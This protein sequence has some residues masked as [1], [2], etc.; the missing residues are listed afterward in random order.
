LNGVPDAGT[1]EP[2][3]LLF[4]LTEFL[5]Y[6]AAPAYL[7]RDFLYQ[8]YVVEKLSTSEIAALISSCQSTVG[9]YLKEYGIIA[10][11]G[12]G[13]QK[14]A[15]FGLAYGKIIVGREELPHQKQQQNIK[16][17]WTLRTRGY[18]YWKI[19]EVFNTMC[20]PTQTGRGRWHARSVKAIMDANRPFNQ[21]NI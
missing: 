18:S 20:I 2:S 12:Q 15:G 6:S 16:K 10:R 21:L 9:K 14:R 4:E 8:K 5:D 3:F 17:M 11:K 1:N 19:A 13:H 7:N